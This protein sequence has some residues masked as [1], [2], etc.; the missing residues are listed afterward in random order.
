MGFELPQNVPTLLLIQAQ[1][2]LTP[3]CWNFILNL[4]SLKKVTSQLMRP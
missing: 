1:G 4:F 3:E 2:K